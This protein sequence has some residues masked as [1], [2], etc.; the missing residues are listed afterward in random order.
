[1]L[2]WFFGF[3]MY[4]VHLWVY[5]YHPYCTDSIIKGGRYRLWG[6]WVNAKNFGPDPQSLKQHPQTLENSDGG[7]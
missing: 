6:P 4:Y 5:P 7:Q 2:E 3:V 1:M